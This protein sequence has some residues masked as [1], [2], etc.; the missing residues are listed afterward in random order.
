MPLVSILIPAYNQ[1]EHLRQAV[2]SVLA[3]DYPEIEIIIG[4]DSTND[5]VEKV[6]ANFLSKPQKFPIE[7]Y[8]HDNSKDIHPG[9]DN[10]FLLRKRY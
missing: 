3:Q 2:E 5:G 8:R 9:L 4:D 1:P 7:Y 10:S 6:V